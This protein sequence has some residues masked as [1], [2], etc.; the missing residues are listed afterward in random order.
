M[1]W[2]HHLGGDGNRGH[3]V[4]WHDEHYVLKKLPFS[5]TLSLWSPRL[6]PRYFRGDHAIFFSEHLSCTQD[7]SPSP[8]CLW[9]LAKQRHQ[10]PLLT[11]QLP[12]P[13]T[14]SNSSHRELPLSPAHQ[15]LSA[16]QPQETLYHSAFMPCCNKRTSAPR[17]A[18]AFHVPVIHV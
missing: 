8:H 6:Q 12:L 14:S 3:R 17:I 4:P 2:L 16:A 15:L 13:G 18:F 11:A 5:L 9:N 10:P 1:V 7:C